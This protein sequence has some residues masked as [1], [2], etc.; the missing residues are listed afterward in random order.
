MPVTAEDE[1]QAR[2]EPF[3]ISQEAGDRL[4]ESAEPSEEEQEQARIAA[5]LTAI[6]GIRRAEVIQAHE[7]H[8]GSGVFSLHIPVLK[9]DTI[10]FSR[11]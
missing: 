4:E 5:D 7:Q 10:C 11:C 1:R 9:I 3:E 2:T 6:E 8:S